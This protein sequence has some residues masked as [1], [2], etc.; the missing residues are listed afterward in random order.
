M[1][2]VTITSPPELADAAALL[3]SLAA[4]DPN[5]DLTVVVVARELGDLDL[6]GATLVTPSD[7]GISDLDALAARLDAQALR[8]ALIGPVLA[9]M[10]EE[11][12]RVIYLNPYLLTVGPLTDL[13]DCLDNNE[14]VLVQH[15]TATTNESR[16]PGTVHTGIFGVR[17]GATSSAVLDEWPNNSLAAPK[18]DGGHHRDCFHAWVDS[19]PGRFDSLKTYRSSGFIVGAAHI[20]PGAFSQDEG[21]LRW[22]G[23]PVSV[24]DSAEMDC[25]PQTTGNG[26]PLAVY[27]LPL[28]ASPELLNA[29]KKLKA[30]AKAIL[31]AAPRLSSFDR[32]PDGTTLDARLRRL[33]GE[34]IDSEAL[35][36]SIFT[37]AGAAD[38]YEWLNQPAHEGAK[39]GLTRYHYAIWEEISD[40]H[41]AY[42]DLDG[43]DG[44]NF[45]IWLNLHRWPVIPMPSRLL[46]TP[47]EDGNETPLSYP[48]DP[49]WGVN[50]AGYFTSELGLGEA[51]RLLIR[52][53]DAGGVRALPVRGTYVPPCDEETEFKFANP[54][55][56]P[57]AINIICMNGD[58]IPSF[59]REAGEGFFRGRYTIALWWWETNTF[60]D[61]WRDAYDFIDEVWVASDLVH[62]AIAPTSPV[63]VNKIPLP[64]S[65]PVTVVPSRSELGM[66][67]GFVFLFVFDYHSTSARK[68]PQGTIKAFRET[69]PPGSGAS[70]VI[71]TIN[72]ANCGW[73]QQQVLAAADGH[74][75]IH[76]IDGYVAAATKNAMLASCDCYVSLHRSEGFGLTPAEAMWFGRPVI[77]TGY[78]G[79]LEFMRPSNSYLVDYETVRV[80]PGA[81][82]Y[83]PDGVWAEP[84]LAEASALMRRVFDNPIEAR[85]KGEQAATDIRRFNSPEVSGAAIAARL[86]GVYDRLLTLT[87]S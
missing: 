82:P 35:S 57:F 17:R 6:P 78:G 30:Q 55:Q 24:V 84:D 54:S 48:R 41:T 60:P 81:D 16:T 10:L 8:R 19:L 53:L 43:E 36:G 63:P 5:A 39:A 14:F 3:A 42:P 67:D 77:A 46:P 87:A 9:S 68:N 20:E 83:P 18:P 38:F 13:S 2:F 47:R 49:V 75:D 32:L 29:V 61:H 51:A 27:P 23:D 15:V 79:V 37:D 7:N 86:R 85:E 71:K 70:L 73:E 65:L 64:V 1:Q 12:E 34:A 72:A 76:F 4:P 11:H 21:L 33:A 44:D 56:A 52:G 28:T 26:E 66:P 31:P 58:V 40:L 59:A 25:N 50:V 74:P 80:G 22:R 69:F 45:A 62:D